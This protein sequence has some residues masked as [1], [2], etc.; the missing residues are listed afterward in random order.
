MSPIKFPG[1]PKNGKGKAAYLKALA[2]ALLVGILEAIVAGINSRS[3]PLA[4]FAF[5]AILTYTIALGV[6][7]KSGQ[8]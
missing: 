3:F 7:S 1:P 5:T 6:F 8:L 4:E 2:L